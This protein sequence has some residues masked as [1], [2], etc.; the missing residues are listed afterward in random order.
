MSGQFSGHVCDEL[1]DTESPANP[2]GT[3]VDMS[4]GNSMTDSN[5]QQTRPT[6]GGSSKDAQRNT[7]TNSVFTGTSETLKVLKEKCSLSSWGK[8]SIASKEPI[9]TMSNKESQQDHHN[10]HENQQNCKNGEAYDG[11]C[12]ANPASGL[13]VTMNDTMAVNPYVYDLYAVCNH[14][15]SDL[16]GGHYTATCRNP[17]DGK[18]YSFD[19]VHTRA[20]TRPDSEVISEDAYILFYQRCFNTPTSGLHHAVAASAT[21]KPTSVNAEHKKKLKACPSIVPQ[22]EHHWVYRMP[23]FSYKGKV[24]PGKTGTQATAT[25]GGS[26]ATK[27]ESADNGKVEAT[28]NTASVTT[29]STK[30][31]KTTTTTRVDGEKVKTPTTNKKCT[32]TTT[33]KNDQELNRGCNDQAGD[34]LSTAASEDGGIANMESSSEDVGTNFQRNSQGKYATL[35]VMPKR[36]LDQ[37]MGPSSDDS[38]FKCD[39]K[40]CKKF[41]RSSMVHRDSSD[42]QRH[43]TSTFSGDVSFDETTEGDRPAKHSVDNQTSG[44]MCNGTKAS[45]MP[46]LNGVMGSTSARGTNLKKGCNHSE[47]ELDVQRPIDKN[48][49]D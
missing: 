43:S 20:I 47:L 31:S 24:A 32:N 2:N 16:Q 42:P 36:S 13:P 33:N 4:Q 22:G 25:T 26:T 21:T 23:D 49:V 5:N 15:G 19:D 9:V 48:D 10:G 27:Q 37:S 41:I 8:S 3:L 17:T 6:S 12:G 18:W 1:P 35:P 45:T 46:V 14:H 11:K 40:I 44:G 34:T 7:M 28:N 30:P 29:S 39:T 38:P